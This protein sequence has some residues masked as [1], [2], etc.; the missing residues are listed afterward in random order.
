M[1]EFGMKLPKKGCKS[2]ISDMGAFLAYLILAKRGMGYD[3]LATFLK[4]TTSSLIRA[5]ERVTPVLYEI[6]KSRWWN[7]RKRPTPLIQSNFRYIALCADSTSIEINR[8]KGRFEEVKNYYDA[9]N[10]I[11]ALKKEC[12]VMASPPYY[13]LFS[14][15]AVT[16]S[17]HDFNIL[18]STYQSYVSYL[19]KRNDEINMITM[20]E[21]FFGRFKSL[22]SLFRKPYRYIHDRFEMNFDICVLLTN[23]HIQANYLEEKDQIFCRNLRNMTRSQQED[24]QKRR[25][26]QVTA[27]KMRKKQRLINS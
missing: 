2:N 9:K 11:Y 17:T 13:C 24:K 23:E 10:K 14:Q 27:S 22:W 7:D 18:K 20:V 26:G 1:E 25:R 19:T 4:M 3:T 21:Q 5:L 16:G 15:R 8:P 12:A 6:L